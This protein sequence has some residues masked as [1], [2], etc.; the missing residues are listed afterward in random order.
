MLEVLALRSKSS[1]RIDDSISKADALIVHFKFW[2]STRPDVG[3]FAGILQEL[4][5]AAWS[6]G[7]QNGMV[8][9]TSSVN[10]W[11]VEPVNIPDYSVTGRIKP[12]EVSV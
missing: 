10:P 2:Q 12:V 8:R 4:L 7:R 9:T 11:L 3:V 5:G 6:I 1:L